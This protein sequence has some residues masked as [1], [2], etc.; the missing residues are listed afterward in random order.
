V[1]TTR[2][3]I[4]Y[5]PLRIGWA[6]RQG[7]IDAFRSAVRLSYALW[8]GRFNPILIVDREDEAERLVD[9]FRVDLIW[10]L[11]ESK[12]VRE[13]Q[14]KF[15]YLI[16]P[17]FA[18]DLFVQGSGT[19]WYSQVLDVHNALAHIHDRPEWKAIQEQGVR[20]YT[21][22]PDD[23]LGDVFLVQFGAYPGTA[24]T[25][26][27][28]RAMLIEA[29][30]ATETLVPPGVISEDDVT[31]HPS[32]PFISRLNV[33]RHYA[34]EAGH[35]HPGF[36]VG[37]A[38][39]VVDL[40]CHW[41]LRAA[42]IPL[43]FVD[44]NHLARYA[45][46]VPAWE[47]AMRPLMAGRREWDRDLAV[48]SRR[49]DIEGA[50]KSLG[51]IRLVLCPVLE[52]GLSVHAPMMHLGEASVLG[53]VGDEQGKP[54]VSFALNEKPFRGD[55]WFYQQHLVVSVSTIGGL[56]GDEQ[57]TFAPPHI[58]ELNEFYART[59]HFEYNKVRAEPGRVGLVIDAA[60]H[61]AFLF[62]LPVADLV[63][64]LFGM[65]GYD[66]KPSAA[67]LIVRQLIA[68]LGGV[69]G[70]R[71]FKIPGVRRLLRIYGP[72]DAFTKG[73]A[74]QLIG[75]EDPD[76][77][78][79]KFADHRDLHIEQRPQGTKLEPIAVFAYLVEKGLI[80]VGVKL[81]C[82]GC[83]LPTWIPVDALRE[84]IVC[85]L[86]GH[87]HDVTRQLVNTEWHYRRSGILGVE[88]NALGAVPV[89]LTLQQLD[90]NLLAGLREGLYS[91]SVT[92]VPRNGA[93]APACEVDFVWLIPNSFTH[94]STR[95]T[96]VILGECKDQ[97]PIKPEKFDRDVENLRRVAD[98]LPSRRFET[99][100]LLSKLAPFT[101]DEI[102]KARTLNGRYQQRTILLT[103]RELE[104]YFMYERVKTDPGRPGPHA[105][106]AEDLAAATA[107]MYF[108]DQ[109]DATT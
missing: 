4:A 12:E 77:P 11:G 90:A 55:H 40:V 22:Q 70:A 13:F 15:P 71:V 95:K 43:L 59:M 61:D 73:A 100:V 72:T 92:L 78:D 101:A 106:T 6:I 21:W 29:A 98:G 51:G 56:H 1:E 24:E 96:V 5:R 69:Q 89:A 33:E 88:R 48:W 54:R 37:D 46:L 14:A 81:S 80:R 102:A 41:N 16:K 20:V 58:P 50:A 104:P 93:N 60:D 39:D 38:G 103:A 97:G 74:L 25:G 3:D 42:D 30:A 49:E 44:T 10:P 67:G 105:G 99:Y 9:L 23:P 91:P 63:Q 26:V 18:N 2:V 108:N 35:S 52:H 28:Y 75:S 34:V 53:V 19:R 84:R 45:A 17:F 87:E 68:R 94:N 65:A 36:F 64:R 62:A 83:Q 8:G 76:N 7:D 66:A 82:P 107:M 109:L 79:A 47:K 57:H 31:G 27:D 85:E 86:C 32:I